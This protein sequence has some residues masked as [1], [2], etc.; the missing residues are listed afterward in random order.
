VPIPD[1]VDGAR[2][3][4]DVDIR[5]VCVTYNSGAVLS[6]F[7]DSLRRATSRSVELVLAD[8]GSTDGA[9]ERESERS[10]ARLLRTGG[11]LGYG[12]AA[13]LG[14]EGFD[15]D[16]LVV[17]N[18][19]IEWGEGA[20]DELILAAGRWPRPGALGP[21]IREPDGSTYP[22]GRAL[23]SLTTGVGHAVFAKVW[24]GN[25]WTSTYQRQQ[26]LTAAVERT[27]GWLSGSCLLLRTD[28]FREIGGF[29]PGYFMFLEDV[30]LGDRLG[31]AGWQNVYVPSAH[32]THLGGH[33]W[34]SAPE[35]MIR[36]HHASMLRYLTRRYDAWYLA[37]LRLALRAGLAVRQSVEIR[38]ARRERGR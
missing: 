37:P 32:V 23:P 4:D 13:N 38:A 17:A 1:Q 5:V 11:N 31:R 19:D 16:W 20:L 24:P 25:P 30:D 18:P 26:E 29:D 6:T 22:S 35:K 7:A 8:N 14:A 36:A 12:R 3:S 15:G 10:G 27:C 9:P 21:L 34:R 33:S 28:A 2:V